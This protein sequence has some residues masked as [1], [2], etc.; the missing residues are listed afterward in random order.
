ME[1]G[2]SQA[3]DDE[4]GL[5]GSSEGKPRTVSK[6]TF[7]GLTWILLFVLTVSE[8]L[9]VAVGCRTLGLRFDGGWVGGF[10]VL[11]WVLVRIA[12]DGIL[13]RL[14]LSRSGK[15]VEVRGRT[16][17]LPEGDVTDDEVVEVHCPKSFIRFVFWG[18]LLGGGLFAL[19]LTFMPRSETWTVGLGY[20]LIGFFGLGAINIWWDRKPQAWADRD[21]ITGYPNGYH[22]RRRFVPW[23]DVAACEIETF[24]NT[25]G[26]PVLI[27]PILKG[28]NGESLLALNLLSTKMKDQERLVR[29][30]KAKLPKTKD[31]FWG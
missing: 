30:I 31:D 9:L 29:F 3:A 1:A 26:K 4:I 16:A 28:W 10:F 14:G 6:G 15:T 8:C 24:C 17:A 27:R 20:V 7:D 19:L 21:G 11:N 13:K 23:S 2:V 12:V 25:F 18:C 5:G 22:L